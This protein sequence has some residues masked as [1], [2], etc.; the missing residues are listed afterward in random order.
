MGVD[1]NAVVDARLKVRGIEGLRIADAS[2]F[3]SIP[4]TNTAAPTI[5]VA[6]KA[7]EYILEEV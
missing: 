7:A 5:M 3:P 1:E 6:E 4:S 2:V